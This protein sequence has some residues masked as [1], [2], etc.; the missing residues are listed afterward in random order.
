MRLS[1]FVAV[2][3][4]LSAARL[5]ALTAIRDGADLVIQSGVK[6]V[7]IENQFDEYAFF[8]TI[9]AATQKNGKYYVVYGSSVLSRGFPAK[10]GYCGAGIETC[11]QWIEI[12]ET[13]SVLN[14]QRGLYESCVDNRHGGLEGWMNGKLHWIATDLMEGKRHADGSAIWR[15]ISFTYDPSNPQIG[16][17]EQS[18][19]EEA[20][21]AEMATPSKPS[22]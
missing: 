10:S 3:M 22:D 13:G 14:T 21:K 5:S 2:A 12:S 16:I 11:I 1:L 4:I 18:I 15:N 6:S 19:I 17:T 7:R 8:V 20:N 9:H